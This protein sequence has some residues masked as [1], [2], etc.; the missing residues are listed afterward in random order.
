MNRPLNIS[1][2]WADIK[3]RRW[4]ENWQRTFGKGELRSCQ[5]CGEL[6]MSKFENVSCGECLLERASDDFMGGL[7]EEN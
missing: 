3:R 1:Q 5:D 4:E 6:V 2:I 7:N